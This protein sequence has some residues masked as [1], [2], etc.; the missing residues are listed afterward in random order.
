MIF[1][2]SFTYCDMKIILLVLDE[3]LEWQCW[4]QNLLSPSRPSECLLLLLLLQLA[5]LSTVSDQM[6]AWPDSTCTKIF[7]LNTGASSSLPS[8]FFSVLLYFKLPSVRRGIQKIAEQRTVSC[9]SLPRQ[10]LL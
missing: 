6:T 3:W 1:I 8:F 10:E 5:R 4:F 9:D 2:L 7:S